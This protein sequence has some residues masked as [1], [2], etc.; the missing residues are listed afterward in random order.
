MKLQPKNVFKLNN[1]DEFDY[2]NLLK[3]NITE[4]ETIVK[5]LLKNCDTLKKKL[6]GEKV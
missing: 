4:R 2:G 1:H 6:Q 3:V 5:K